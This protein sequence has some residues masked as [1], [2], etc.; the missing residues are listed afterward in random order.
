MFE[1]HNPPNNPKAQSYIIKNEDLE[2][3]HKIGTGGFGE[4][5][6]GKYKPKN[7]DVAIK[8][9][10]TNEI[11][12]EFWDEIELQLS[13]MNRFILQF[14]GF[15]ST[16]PYCI[17]T[18]FMPNGSLYSALHETSSKNILSATDLTIIAYCIASGMDYLHSKRIIH[19][20]L[21]SL[22]VLL[23]SHFLPR[24][25]DFGLSSFGECQTNP[26]VG[27]AAIMAP[28]ILKNDIVD[29]P[30]D[31]FSFGMILWE[32][33]TRNIPFSDNDPHQIVYM[34]SRGIR[35]TI[36]DDT[37]E[38]LSQTIS[39]C[40]NQDPAQ[41]PTFFEISEGFL[42]GKLFFKGTVN[43][44][45]STFFSSFGFGKS[46]HRTS[47]APQMKPPFPTVPPRPSPLLIA[48]SPSGFQFEFDTMSIE[49]LTESL[50]HVDNPK[51]ELAIDFI[52]E[53]NS[54]VLE[55][56]QSFWSIFLPLIISAPPQF[57][58]RIIKLLII[59]ARNSS[60]FNH[61]HNVPDLYNYLT[62]ESLDFF[63]YIVSNQPSMIEK[64]LILHLQV[65]ALKSSPEIRSKTIIL[66]CNILKF[67]KEPELK[68]EVIMFL[69]NAMDKY[70]DLNCGH[71]VAKSIA[72]FRIHANMSIDEI[73]P[74]GIKMVSSN[75]SENIIAGYQILLSN[76][77][78]MDCLE[79]GNCYKHMLRS[80]SPI[81]DYA[82]EYVR[83]NIN[84]KDIELVSDIALAL[85]KSYEVRQTKRAE[86][87]LCHLADQ[88][89]ISHLFFRE[90]VNTAL[91]CISNDSASG[92]LTVVFLLLRMDKKFFTNHPFFARYMFSVIKYSSDEGFAAACTILQS[93]NLD[94]DSLEIF[95]TNGVVSILCLRI[96]GCN[97]TK[98]LEYAI[99]AL[100]VFAPK[101]FTPYYKNAVMA[102]IPFLNFPLGLTN[103]IEELFR[104]LKEFPDICQYM[105]EK[106]IMN[107]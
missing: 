50:N 103:K 60:V 91:F 71:I 39:M 38:R 89:D 13:L 37:P 80:E 82:I 97:N 41:R 44:S 98:V 35:P 4:V 59:G 105:Q 72:N 3:F 22:N 42:S 58:P 57:I 76:E 75:I 95:N 19:R 85:I 5:Y 96:A 32:M 7:L 30:S 40:W 29:F 68:K 70:I 53:H 2:I 18:E 61:I 88:A 69:L 20:D 64:T 81:R 11:S 9:L 94:N 56:G 99:S 55:F 77:S 84:S 102:L 78:K 51:F 54:V 27:T 6:V 33:S 49:E 90:V 93:L 92:L 83:R 25:C 12:K 73:L 1:A 48:H 23:D 45:V 8:R 46:F 66:L 104:I 17:V 14:V 47:S 24:I 74:L 15:T 10:L 16:P 43:E 28:E 87:L 100:L 67:G 107:K 31:V 101:I 65:L 79:I 106:G 21:K 34:I 63:L 62:P 52:E 36:P 26:N 86:L